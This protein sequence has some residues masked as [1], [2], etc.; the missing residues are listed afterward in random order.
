MA[1]VGA[2]PAPTLARPSS[3]LVSYSTSDTAEG[4]LA[5]EGGLVGRLRRMR[6]R[7]FAATNSIQEC[8][9]KSCR[10]Y[11]V[12]MITATYRPGEE[13]H[14]R[15]ITGLIKCYRAWAARK[16]IQ[17]AYVWVLEL[18]KRGVPHYHLLIWIPRGFT[19]PLPDKQGWWKHGHTSAVWARHPIG[20][21]AKYMSKGDCGALPKSARVDGAGGLDGSQRAL[22]SWMRAPGWLQRF[23]PRGHR[24]LKRRESWWEDATTG[25]RF[26]SP[27]VLEGW[28]NGV[29][30]LRW[31]GW[32]VDDVILNRI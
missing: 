5:L 9:Q 31:V 15:H 21:I 22:C 10:R 19:P 1:A 30:T 2:L 6:R 13:R 20:Y 27:W 23:V 14:A 32:T 18:T 8:L 29:I 7:V 28:S 25:N 17:I 26:R 11:R 24:I 16:N 3:G 4:V 12:A